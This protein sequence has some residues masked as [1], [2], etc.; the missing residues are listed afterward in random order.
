MR[1]MRWKP[2]LATL[3]CLLL[4]A[5]VS[6]AGDMPDGFVRVND[7]MPA[8]TYEVRYFTGDN[9]VG[10]RIDGYAAPVVILSKPAAEALKGVQADLA[11]FGLGLKVFDGF[12]PQ[13]AVNHFVRWAEDVADTRTKAAYYPNVEKRHL[14]RDGY[15]AAKSGHSRGSTVDVTLI[16]LTTGAELDMG[17]PF[18]WFGPRSWPENPDMTTQVR[19]NRALL[20]WAMT[21]NGFKPLTEEW[22][23]FTLRDEPYPDTYFDFIVQ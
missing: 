19:A 1:T 14:F 11:P 7:L 6:H 2:T 9:F 12:R 22:W 5:V 17:T 13:R 16:D 4:I 20:R 3:L 8:A 15:I 18:D 23:H 21:S 10:E